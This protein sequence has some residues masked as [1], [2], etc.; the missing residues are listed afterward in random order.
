MGTSGGL[1]YFSNLKNNWILSGKPDRVPAGKGLGGHLV[2]F[3]GGRT[4]VDNS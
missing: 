1:V 3:S 4:E 2:T